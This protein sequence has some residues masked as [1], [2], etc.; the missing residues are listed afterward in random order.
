MI[1]AENSLG[2]MLDRWYDVASDTMLSA[3]QTHRKVLMSLGG[4][5]GFEGLYFRVI[6]KIYRKSR[7]TFF[8]DDITMLDAK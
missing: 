8:R 6:I 3:F 5:S 7:P 1:V 4:M 2:I